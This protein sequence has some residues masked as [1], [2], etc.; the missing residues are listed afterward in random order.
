MKTKNI[1]ES[2]GYIAAINYVMQVVKETV[3]STGSIM[4]DANDIVQKILVGENDLSKDEGEYYTLDMI[5]VKN[6]KKIIA[7]EDAL[8]NP[9]FNRNS[10]DLGKAFDKIKN[11]N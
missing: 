5:D 4:I 1:S 6:P 11:S 8:L 10:F 3:I 9:I 7:G 2:L